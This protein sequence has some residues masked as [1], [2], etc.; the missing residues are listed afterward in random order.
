[1]NERVREVIDEL[2]RQ[3][4]ADQV[5]EPDQIQSVFVSMHE[6]IGKELAR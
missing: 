4:N 3:L 5:R 2:F 1:M 6:R